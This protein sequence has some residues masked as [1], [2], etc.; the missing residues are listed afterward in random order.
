MNAPA[1]Q[2][3]DQTGGPTSGHSSSGQGSSGGTPMERLTELTRRSEQTMSEAWEQWSEEARELLG[4]VRERGRHAR[5]NPEE[6]LD[7]M[8]DFGERLLARQR[9]FA[10][11]VLAAASRVRHSAG[12][13]ARSTADLADHAADQA[14]NPRQ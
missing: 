9:G 2:T 14:T 12:D 8:F 5:A 4:E 10:K 3:H 13:T 6:V 1:D 7:A 11:D